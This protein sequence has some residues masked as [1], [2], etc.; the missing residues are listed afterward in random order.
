MTPTNPLWSFLIELVQRLKTK[1]PKFF[2][3][4]QY[5]TGLLGAITGLP[6]FLAQFSI[7]LPPTW[8]ALE[9][10]Y[11]AWASVGFLIASQLTTA[12]PAAT[13]TKD[14]VVLTKTDEKK[15]PF[16]GEAEVKAAQVKQVPNSSLTLE[17]TK[18]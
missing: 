9:N 14:G 1:K 6:A 4:L 3:V 15:L 11:V 13:V 7:T 12:T 2:V 8:L 16:T 10:K 18:K 5:I 17:E